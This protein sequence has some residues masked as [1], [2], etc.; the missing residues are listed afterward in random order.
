MSL[1]KE[2]L[3]AIRAL[4]QE[5]NAPIKADIRAI[6]SRLDSV[7]DTL[8]TVKN[9]QIRVE[10]EQFPRIAAALD[11]HKLNS[12]KLDAIQKNL[13]DITPTVQA[14]DI[15]HQTGYAK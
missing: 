8:Q 7:E 2:D 4:M 6:S 11:G 3:Q 14:L 1:T 10:L 5:E 9:S 12:E 13:E 15:L